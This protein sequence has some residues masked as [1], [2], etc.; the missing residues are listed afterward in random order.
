MT[1]GERTLTKLAQA[2]GLTL[3]TQHH[4]LAAVLSQ[5]QVVTSVEGLEHRYNTWPWG[6][7]QRGEEYVAYL[8]S[9]VET[10]PDLLAALLAAA[11]RHVDPD[12]GA[13]PPGPWF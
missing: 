11:R 9:G 8:D 2:R 12:T 7:A 13:L 6:A 3:T 5:P 1:P 10:Y 4:A